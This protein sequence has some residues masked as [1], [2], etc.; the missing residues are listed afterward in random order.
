MPNQ[1]AKLLR[2][3]LSEGDRYEGRPLFQA[4]LDKCRELGMSGATVFQGLEGY[5]ETAEIHRH[6]LIRHDQPIVIMI[7]DQPEA[8]ARLIP[9]VE[10]MMDTGLIAMSDVRVKRVQK[11][12][13]RLD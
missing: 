13:V 5:G 10:V 8:L 11:S 9:F 12:Q 6:H 2:V 3:H 7:I 1:T 4:I